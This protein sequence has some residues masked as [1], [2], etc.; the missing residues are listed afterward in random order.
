MKLAV[1]LDDTNGDPILREGQR[2]EQTARAGA[3]L[4][5]AVRY[6]TDI[7]TLSSNSR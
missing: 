2:K 6:R 3:S 7:K 4:R 5:R 1:L